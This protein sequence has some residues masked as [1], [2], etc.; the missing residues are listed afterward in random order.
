LLPSIPLLVLPMHGIADARKVFLASL[1]GTIAW[2]GLRSLTGS[3]GSHRY[4][5]DLLALPSDFAD[6]L[7]AMGRDFTYSRLVIGPILFAILILACLL[8][9]VRRLQRRPDVF[10]SKTMGWLSFSIA[11]FAFTV[12][13]S[14]LTMV[15][16]AQS[17]F[18]L[19]A[20]AA[21]LYGVLLCSSLLPSSASKVLLAL[22]LVL[23]V[24]ASV[25][26]NGFFLVTK[27]A[28][29][30]ADDSFYLSRPWLDRIHKR[31][32]I[33]MGRGQTME[34]ALAPYPISVLRYKHWMGI[35]YPLQSH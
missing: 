22:V 28:L 32:E 15:G 27:L 33:A 17:R 2:L 20:F 30:P 13:A 34:E 24:S 25:Y 8:F 10:A 16:A 21:G 7:I 11:L 29:P 3:S 9:I 6:S 23:Y 19:V 35:P 31:V 18:Y 4:G 14:H 5:V 12:L 26:R 1:S